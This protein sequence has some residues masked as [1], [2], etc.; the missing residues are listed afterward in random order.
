MN[1][2]PVQMGAAPLVAAALGRVF[3]VN[4]VWSR[5]A[6]TAMT[7]KRTI[8]LPMLPVTPAGANRQNR[9]GVYSS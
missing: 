6:S 1:V 5:Q 3:G 8:V 2:N 9:L 4:V 7:D